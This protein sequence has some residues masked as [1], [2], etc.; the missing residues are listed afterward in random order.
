VLRDRYLVPRGVTEAKLAQDLDIS[1]AYVVELVRG[2]RHVTTETALRLA[3]VTGIDANEWLRLQQDWDAWRETT[4][5][6]R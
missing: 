1:K 6:R 3:R 5:R 4:V 2:K